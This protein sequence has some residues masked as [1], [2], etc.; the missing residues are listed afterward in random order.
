M[1]FG[2]DRGQSRGL[3]RGENA[4][5][6]GSEMGERGGEGHFDFFRAPVQLACKY[7]LLHVKR[8]DSY[9]GVRFLPVWVL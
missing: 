7:K 3:S 9:T 8:K 5:R 6:I 2:G 4:E 1:R